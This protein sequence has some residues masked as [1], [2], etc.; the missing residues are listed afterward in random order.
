MEEGS[1]DQL[2]VL[3]QNFPWETKETHNNLTQNARWFARDSSP[4]LSRIQVR[5]LTA[6]ASL[7]GSS[8]LLLLL[9]SDVLLTKYMHLLLQ[10][11]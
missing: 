9:P 4:T 8:H 11:Q 2:N 3:S 6:W 10:N 7:F 5:S 1:R